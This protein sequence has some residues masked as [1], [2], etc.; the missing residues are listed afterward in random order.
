MF[1][2]KPL[3]YRS[4]CHS[5]WH[6]LVNNQPL[7][8]ILERVPTLSLIESPK[9]LLITELELS[10]SKPLTN[11]MSGSP[12]TESQIKGGNCCWWWVSVDEEAVGSVVGEKS[13]KLSSVCCPGVCDAESVFWP[14]NSS[15]WSAAEAMTIP[16][17]SRLV[18]FWTR[19]ELPPLQDD[20]IFSSWFRTSRGF[21][22]S[23]DAG[24]WSASSLAMESATAQAIP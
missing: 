7:T 21:I 3:R 5:H 13:I 14:D 18:I 22:P 19:I 4:W 20:K 16:P 8:T 15:C 2:S 1:F 23:S 11:P 17:L 9:N 6:P 24:V 10:C 12:V